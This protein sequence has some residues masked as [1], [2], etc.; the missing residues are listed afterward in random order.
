VPAHVI[1]LVTRPFTGLDYNLRLQIAA[2]SRTGDSNEARAARHAAQRLA[3]GY[4]GLRLVRRP[5]RYGGAPGVLLRGLPGTAPAADIVLAHR[6]AVYL[7]IVPGTA[8][9]SDQRRAL[10]SLRFIPRRGPFPSGNP[11]A[12]TTPP[13]GRQ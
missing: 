8:V 12:P 1:T 13:S 5:V 4:R 2:W 3:S 7:I 6:G 9:S 10:D 11:V